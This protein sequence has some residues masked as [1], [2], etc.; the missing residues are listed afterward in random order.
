MFLFEEMFGSPVFDMKNMSGEAILCQKDEDSLKINE[1]V[2]A[3]FPGQKMTFY[4][5]ES[6]ICEDQ[7]KQHN[8]QLNFINTITTS[9]MPPHVLNLKVEAIIIVAQELESKG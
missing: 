1:Q 8:F 6:I 3:K 9:G 2:S 5:A 4:N 7:E